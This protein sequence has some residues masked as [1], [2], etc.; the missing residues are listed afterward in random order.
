MATTI[1]KKIKHKSGTTARKAANSP[2]PLA[3]FIDRMT[4]YADA[5]PLF[6]CYRGQR[7]AAWKNVPALFRP[8]LAKLAQSEKRA[9]RDLVSVHPNEFAGDETMFDRLVR[10]QHFGLP[11]RLMDVSQNPLVALYFATDP[12]PDGEESDGAVTAFAVPEEREKYFDSDSVSCLANLA[13]M[14]ADEK[15]EIIKLRQMRL[16]GTTRKAEIARVNGEDVYERL[17][18]FI[19]AE[20]PHFL[21]IID[22]ID[23][24]KP[25][26][27]HPKM[28]N[29]RILSQA[30]GFIIHGLVPRRKIVFAH[31]IQEAKFVI[32][33]AEKGPLR[34]AL[35]LLGI[36]DSTLF[37]EL[38]RAAN[39]IKTSY[40][41]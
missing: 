39:R 33:L 35:E 1:T 29:R 15:D 13:N 10:M 28:S 6:K 4:A 41:A 38:D 23:L 14:T 31:P 18:Q 12:G 37:P 20:K 26:Y 3:S 40:S 11:S 5:Q 16:K 7:N 2:T 19:R 25:Y 27:V 32:P 21:P 17:H 24:F 8:D 34:K 36:S 9:V 22:P 30:G